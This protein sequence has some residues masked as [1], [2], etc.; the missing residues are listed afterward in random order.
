VVLLLA[1]NSRSLVPQCLSAYVVLLLAANSRSLVPQCLSAYV[2]LLLAATSLLS[3]LFPS[4]TTAHWCLNVSL[5]HVVLLL[6]QPT[7]AHWL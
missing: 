4:L 6:L 5:P 7:A 1:A 3:L 2:V